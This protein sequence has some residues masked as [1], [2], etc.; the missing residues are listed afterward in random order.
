MKNGIQMPVSA[1]SVDFAKLVELLPGQVYWKDQN[2]IILGCNDLQVK[3][4]G[5]KSSDEIIGRTGYDLVWQGLPPAERQRQA[6]VNA[7]IDKS[8]MYSGTT[9]TREE[10]ITTAEG[11][12]NYL[13][14][15]IPLKDAADRIIG[16]LSIAIEMSESRSFE[17]RPPKK[18]RFL[19]IQESLAQQQIP[20]NDPHNPSLKIL[21][22]EDNQIASKTAKSLLENLHH[23]V[24]TA[25]NSVEAL[26]LFE[27]HKYD[28]IFTDVG[29]PDL[30]GYKLTEQLRKIEENT[31][32]EP[33]PIIALTAH[34][35]IN[36]SEK[37][38]ASG[39]NAILSKP[40]QPAEV[41]KTLNQ[42]V[43]HQK[44]PA[45]ALPHT[46][47]PPIQN[48]SNRYT[49]KAIDLEDGAKILGKD[50][51]VALKMLEDLVLTFPAVRAEIEKAYRDNNLEDLRESVHKFYGG[52]CYVGVPPLRQAGKEL[53]TALVK[54]ETHQ[55][56]RL[57]QRLRDEMSSV[58][59]E[60]AIIKNA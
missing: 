22:V 49:K 15:R 23:E 25:E 45:P 58:E 43:Y 50:Q 56:N 33:V 51:T 13:V 17:K 3:N 44:A 1:F 12:K 57:Y 55:I 31:D 41:I 53:E 59:K 42:F 60:F 29:L 21:L 11:T 9:N 8:V 14:N 54:Q 32:A 39:M 28:I 35:S 18:K 4:L 38:A 47:S 7:E 37:A 26:T 20:L 30:D 36:I 16:L 40:L 5:L 2:S 19:L 24:E 6:E 27:P 52:L 34:D 46:Q 48:T 10:L